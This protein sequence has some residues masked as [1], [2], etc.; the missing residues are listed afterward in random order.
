M[1]K[2]IFLIV[3]LFL[4][5]GCANPYIG[6]KLPWD[7]YAR[8]LDGTTGH[9]EVVKKHL[10]FN[11]D[12][13]VDKDDRNVT[14]KGYTA[15]NPKNVTN[16]EQAE[17]LVFF[18]LTDKDRVVTDYKSFFLGDFYDGASLCEKR[19]FEITSPKTPGFSYILWGYSGNMRQ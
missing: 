15:C 8:S 4:I 12:Y 18:V 5:S 9:H 14:L 1:K 2:I 7:P 11:Y 19:E 17:L 3:S 13:I 16:W 10:I 6:K